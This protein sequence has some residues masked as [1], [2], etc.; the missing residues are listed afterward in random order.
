MQQEFGISSGQP[1]LYEYRCSDGE[2]FAAVAATEAGAFRVLCAE[3]PGLYGA[4]MR[5]RAAH[6]V[7]FRVYE[8]V[9]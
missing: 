3:R 8:V 9:S 1:K 5:V 4:L 6:Q 7:D 2:G